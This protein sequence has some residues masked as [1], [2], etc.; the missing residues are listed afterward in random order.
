MSSWYCTLQF[1]HPL[2]LHTKVCVACNF[3]Y[4]RHIDLKLKTSNW[5][6]MPGPN[7]LSHQDFP[8]NY[9]LITCDL[10]DKE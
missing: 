7:L 4:I 1:I 2:R 5:L 10:L 9:C 3:L 8:V 6:V